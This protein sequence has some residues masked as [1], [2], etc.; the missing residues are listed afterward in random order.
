MMIPGLPDVASEY[1]ATRM[2][3]RYTQKGIVTA[4]TSRQGLGGLGSAGRSLTA[5]CGKRF[6]A[7]A[8]PNRVRAVTGEIM[9]FF[10]PM[11]AGLLGIMRPP[12][13]AR[14]EAPVK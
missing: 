1:V 8:G 2:N 7:L 14:N 12:R 4:S 6:S 9:E 13:L 3:A 10:R 5:P 11:T